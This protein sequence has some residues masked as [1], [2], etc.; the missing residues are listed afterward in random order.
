MPTRFPNNAWAYVSLRRIPLF[1]ANSLRLL[2]LRT[3][4]VDPMLDSSCKVLE[5]NHLA[6]C[7][8]VLAEA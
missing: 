6:S 5:T 1:R 2:Q 8:T 7:W 3:M 4:S